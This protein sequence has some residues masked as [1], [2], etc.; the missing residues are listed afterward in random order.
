MTPCLQRCAHAGLRCAHDEAIIYDNTA[1]LSARYA[2]PGYSDQAFPREIFTF[3][4]RWVEIAILA[5]YDVVCG[6]FTAPSGR[7]SIFHSLVVLS[8]QPDLPSLREFKYSP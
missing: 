8:A 6:D 3:S 4:R 1:L 5:L 2:E 7:G